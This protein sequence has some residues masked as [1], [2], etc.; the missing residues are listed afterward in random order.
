MPSQPKPVDPLEN[1]FDFRVKLLWAYEGPLLQWRSCLIETDSIPSWI[2]KRGSVTLTSQTGQETFGTGCWIFPKEGE[3]RQDFSEDA[4][5]LSI[6]FA[7]EWPTGQT[8]FDRSRTLT[9]PLTEAP[10]LT[11]IA[12]RLARLVAQNYPGARAELKTLPGSPEKYF[13]FNRLLFAWMLEYTTT[14]KKIGMAPQIMAQIDARVRMAVHTMEMRTVNQPLREQQL[15]RDAGLS[16]SQLNRLFVRELGK[17]PAEYWEEKR[18]RSARL[19]LLRSDQ[20]IKSIAFDLG[21]SSLPH[22]STWIRKK[23]GKSP[24]QL[25]EEGVSTIT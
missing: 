6:R 5:I 8:L 20:N 15:A 23:F 22:F 9:V 18:I 14:M 11:R 2:L 1:W 21:F 24:R 25:R 16:V 10:H 19:A 4:E 17:T 3:L 13:E 12:E 7:A